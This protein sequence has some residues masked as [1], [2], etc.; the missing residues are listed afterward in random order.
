[1]KDPVSKDKVEPWSM[2]PPKDLWSPPTHQHVHIHANTYSSHI[3]V[4]KLTHTRVHTCI[5]RHLSETCKTERI[6][7][8]NSEKGEEY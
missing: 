2:I 1:M 7:K 5:S 4:C 6:E 3:F 8:K